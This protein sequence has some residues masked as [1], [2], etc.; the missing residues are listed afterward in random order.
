M[1]A[2]PAANQLERAWMY[3]APCKH[4]RHCQQHLLV[5]RNSFTDLQI[6]ILQDRD[7]TETAILVGP[8]KFVAGFW[9]LIVP[10]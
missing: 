7:V 5:E 1:I 10:T 4:T 9:P 6:M 3:A 8:L 2:N